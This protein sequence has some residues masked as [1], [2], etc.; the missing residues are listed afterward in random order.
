MCVCVC[1]LLF[2]ISLLP[3][4]YMLPSLFAVASELN[5][6]MASGGKEKKGEEDSGVDWFKLG[7]DLFD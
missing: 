7:A 2:I 5:S 1:V 3:T 6:E 4:N